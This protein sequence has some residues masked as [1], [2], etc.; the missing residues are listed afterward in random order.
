VEENVSIVGDSERVSVYSEL[1]T[2]TVEK[3]FQV[4]S[5]GTCHSHGRREGGGLARN[6][7]PIPSI[8]NLFCSHGTLADIRTFALL[9][10]H[11]A[12]LTT[13]NYSLA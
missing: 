12:V 2:R 8:F 13:H 6:L 4:D 1:Q 11:L 7:I 3:L 10:S 5:R 9:T